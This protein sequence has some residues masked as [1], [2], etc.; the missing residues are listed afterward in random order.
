MTE[1]CPVGALTSKTYRFRSRPWDLH[2]TQTTCTQ[3]GVG[4]QMNVDER[5]GDVLR[6]MSVADDDIVS[7][8]WL[9]DRGR[10]NIGFYD[11]ARR[12]TSPLLRDGG[13]WVQID[14]DDAIATVGRQDPQTRSRQAGKAPSPRSAAAAC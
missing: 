10:Y 7:D 2:R 1:L 6:T 3:C 4:C 14:W 5:H 9:C 13:E 8:G 12:V 11:D